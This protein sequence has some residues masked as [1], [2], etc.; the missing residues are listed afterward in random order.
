MRLSL[1]IALS[2]GM[3]F[4]AFAAPQW[5]T[6]LVYGQNGSCETNNLTFN[7]GRFSK[8]D[9]KKIRDNL[10][11]YLQ[12]ILFIEENGEVK[13]RT[14]E[15]GLVSCKET[16]QGTVCSYRPFNDTKKIYQ[17]SWNITNDELIIDHLG[18]IKIIRPDFPWTGYELTIAEG[19][20]YPESVGEKVIGG[21]VQ[22]NFNKDD[23]NIASLCQ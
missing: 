13:L 2:L 17:S 18:T 19:F 6:P 1:F 12:I 4:S 20:L 8:I 14:T 21:K 16:Q 11:V 10:N 23:K 15:Q 22:V 7:A 3:V 9:L 5:L